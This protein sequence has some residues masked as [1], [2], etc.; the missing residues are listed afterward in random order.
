MMTGT[1][2]NGDHP[3]TGTVPSLRDWHIQIIREK[4]RQGWQ[5]AVGYG[6]RSLAEMAMFRY[7]ILISPTLRAR[8][9]VAQQVRQSNFASRP[10][11]L[12]G[13]YAPTPCRP[14]ILGQSRVQ[15]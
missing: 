3:T 10:F 4:S 11:V 2:S 5:R 6:Q 13:I 15:T 9:F 7:K 14:C 1:A 12:D 8:K